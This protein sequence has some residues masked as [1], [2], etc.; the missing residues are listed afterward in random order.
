MCGYLSC[1]FYWG[2]GPQCKACALIGNQTCDPLFAGQ[3]FVLLN[4][5]TFFTQPFK[6]HSIWKL[7]KCS[8]YL[9]VCFCSA[10][11]ILFSRF[12]SEPVGFMYLLPL[13]LVELLE[14]LTKRV[15]WKCHVSSDCRSKKSMHFCLELLEPS[16]LESWAAMW[17]VWLPWHYCA[18]RQPKPF[19]EDTHGDALTYIVVAES[20]LPSCQTWEW[21]ACRW[22]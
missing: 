14:S 13:N 6:Y 1:S 9:W 11:F 18:T 16:L 5:F 21:R 15:C 2:R 17:K 10:S 3:H 22:F 8:L 4:S 7:S 20:S 12:S 19:W